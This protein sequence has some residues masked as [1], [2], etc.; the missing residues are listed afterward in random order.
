M[1]GEYE[2][3][4]RA[5]RM[6]LERRREEAYGR[7][8]RLRAIEEARN[9]ALMAHAQALRGGQDPETARAELEAALARLNGEQTE[10]LAA[11]GCPADHL[12][13]HYRCETCK[14]TGYVGDSPRRPCACRTRRQ[15]V[16]ACDPGE[17]FEAFR[18]DLF[19]EGAQRRQMEQA[20]RMAEAFA[21]AF[22]GKPSPDTLLLLG[23]TGLGKSYLLNCI[24]NRAL[25]RGEAA[26]KKATAFQ[27]FQDVLRGIRV[28]EDGAAAYIQPKLLLIDDLGAEPEMQN[29][30]KEYLF[31][32]LNERREAGRA[33]AIASNLDD[34]QLLA[35]Y[36][37]RIFSRLFDAAHSRALLLKGRSLRLRE[38]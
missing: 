4:R 27:M 22:P 33:L 23:N 14:D 16:N 1:N 8:P 6:A 28:G 38:R 9:D 25:S 17:S 26:V 10:R 15:L 34:K 19:P 35:R 7:D 5:E 13:L 12:A 24:A 18:L 11:L 29:I 30:T 37:D 2:S 32:I 20:R 3:I 36:G 31:N 21:D